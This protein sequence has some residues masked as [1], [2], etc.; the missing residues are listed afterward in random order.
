MF[1]VQNK[2][3]ALPDAKM[4]IISTMISLSEGVTM[5]NTFLILLHVTSNI[6]R[7]IL[8]GY[9]LTC[10]M[11]IQISFIYAFRLTKSCNMKGTSY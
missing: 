8:F 10:L 9:F 3:G 1:V 11:Q 4:L 7:V 5:I 2:P 6:G